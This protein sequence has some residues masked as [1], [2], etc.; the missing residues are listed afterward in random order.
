MIVPTELR[1]FGHTVSGVVHI[2]SNDGHE[3]SY[4]LDGGIQDIVAFDPVP[5]AG[6]SFL[7]RYGGDER[8]MFIPTA[9]GDRDGYLP[10]MVTSEHGQQS[11]F[12][13]AINETVAWGRYR[14]EYP[15]HVPVARFDTFIRLAPVAVTEKVRRCDCLVI[16]VQGFEMHVLTGMGAE[17]DHF[18]AAG[19]ECSTPPAYEGEASAEEIADFMASR[20]FRQMTKPES[21]GDV[22]FLRSVKRVE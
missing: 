9:F 14:R 2:G 4:Y 1:K 21:H 18:M 15:L 16:D 12:L 11:T 10:I 5:K 19:I 8:I 7:W 22:L 13:P 17:L 6:A 3:I 20:G